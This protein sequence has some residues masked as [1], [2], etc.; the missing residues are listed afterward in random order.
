MP[1]GLSYWEKESFFCNHHAIIIGSGIVVLNAAIHLQKLVPSLKIAIPE[2]DLYLQ[3]RI[4]KMRVL[5]I[6]EAFLNQLSE[7]K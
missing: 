6:S 5:L 4:P 3:M 1:T 2:K 7:K